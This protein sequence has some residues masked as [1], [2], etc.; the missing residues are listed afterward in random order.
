MNAGKD[1]T[2]HARLRLH[3]AGP[4]VPLAT[5]A[6]AD[7]PP[8]WRLSVEEEDGR[9][10]LVFELR[11]TWHE[12]PL[13]LSAPIPLAGPSGWLDAVARYTG[14]RL[15]LFVDGALVDEEWPIGSPAR[16]GDEQ[17]L[18]GAQAAPGAPAFAGQIDG[19]RAWDRALSDAEIAALGA[20]DETPPARDTRVL[21]PDRPVG[22]YW[23]PR[24]RNAFVGDCMP[25]FHQGRFHLFYLFDRRHHRSK[26]GLGAHQWA[27]VSTTDLVHWE[28]HPMAV[29]I[30]E[31]WE[32]SICTG[33]L[34]RHD[35]AC[36]AF[37][38]TRA[39]DGSPALLQVAVSLDG[40]HF[41]K[42][43]PLGILQ[44]PYA[45]APARDPLVFRDERTGVFH[46]LVTTELVPP[47]PSG[48]PGCLAHL[49]STDLRHWEQQPPFLAPGYNDQPEC[50]DAFF[51][52]GWHYLVFSSH[53]VA[54]YRLSRQPHG[55][56]SAP[57]ADA[58]D[59]PQFRVMKTAAFTGDRRIGAAFL[60]VQGYAGHV[61]FREIVQAEDGR[62]GT[63]FVPEMA[64]AA[65]DALDA[66]WRPL[67]PGV[68]C[69]GRDV[70]VQAWE[71]FNAA[72]LNGAP[73]NLRLTC[74][75]VPQPGSAAFG[76]CLRGASDYADGHE[77]R[78][79]PG[80]GKVGW[81][82]PGDGSIPENEMQAIYDVDGL[83][84]PFTL[85]VIARDDVLD[86]CIDGRRT[87]VA[88]A[89]QDPGGDRLFLFAHRAEARFEGLE[90]RPLE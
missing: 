16:H 67:A 88:R 84:R 10:A 18:T 4:G 36:Y 26:W 30:T 57:R 39:I 13:R 12:R 29:P 44:P 64:P 55:P 28:R 75:V 63:R 35:G 50:A 89:E 85:E 25:F 32:G 51:W 46:M 37:Y 43:P 11:T 14:P 47:P 61:V 45:P 34:L 69:A 86:V 41:D 54:R 66:D 59:G 40:V 2:V 31:E 77:L 82:R 20:A 81:R 76:V 70:T 79:E 52:R 83:D 73:R 24:D 62:L 8:V 15:E 9:P 78:C 48:H 56:W 23:K 71:G 68:A 19:V 1:F 74:R 21:G 49:T 42:T 87:L 38:A 17:L 27:H 72:A 80:R 22:Q 33:S 6:G 3:G 58:F 60:P 65:G 90:V 53:G 5:L 7:S